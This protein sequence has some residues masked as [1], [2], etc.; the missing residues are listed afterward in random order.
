[1]LLLGFGAAPSLLPEGR[2]PNKTVTLWTVCL[3]SAT[4]ILSVFRQ[5]P[6]YRPAF[7]L[8]PVGPESHPHAI[9]WGEDDPEPA[10]GSCWGRGC[11]MIH[12]SSWGS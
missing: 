1:M 9:S 3:K 4:R 5:D 11:F 6:A 7:D 2:F 12:L 10:M 8:A